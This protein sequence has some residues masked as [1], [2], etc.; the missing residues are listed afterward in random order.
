VAGVAVGMVS[1][2]DPDH[3]NRLGRY[4]LLTD[5]LGI[6]DY[7]GDMDFKLACTHTG[8]TALQADFKLNGVPLSIIMEAIVAGRAGCK[9]ILAIMAEALAQPR[10]ARKAN[11]PVTE[12]LEV[13]PHKR[14]RLLG[15]GGVNLKRILADTGVQVTPLNEA[16]F[17]IFAPSPAALAEAKEQ[18]NAL[19]E[20][21]V[22][23]QFEFGAVYTARV[24]ELRESG[25]LVRLH[26][27]SAPV[28][29]HN[30][31]LDQRPVRHPS[32]LGFEVGHDV[33]VK[34]FGRDPV[35]GHVRLSR[36]VLQAPAGGRVINLQ[37][38]DSQEAD[39][40]QA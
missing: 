24:V 10:P 21:D 32:A 40:G 18:L 25:L 7:C 17:T 35:S 6:E 37:P 14:A 13:P 26:P 39:T 15:P 36:K 9:H 3:P 5:I 29:L 11:W 34:Y 33:Q 38:R 1:Y 28:L 20:A 31:Q 27:A 12:P 8:V 4:R 22:E 19:L 16:T 23:P 2:P 30:S